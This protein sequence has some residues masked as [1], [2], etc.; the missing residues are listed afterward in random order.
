MAALTAQAP[1]AGDTARGPS[2]DGHTML[3][4]KTLEQNINTVWVY[5][6]IDDPERIL[7]EAVRFSSG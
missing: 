3:Q 2:D 5:P 1:A 7:P 4:A 6:P